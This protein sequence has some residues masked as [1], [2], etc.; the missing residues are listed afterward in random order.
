MWRDSRHKNGLRIG[1]LLI[2]VDTSD[3]DFFIQLIPREKMT[4]LFFM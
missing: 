1:T 2:D 4:E 3:K